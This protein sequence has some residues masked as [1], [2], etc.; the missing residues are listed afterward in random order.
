MNY[1]T[2][3]ALA[4]AYAAKV[5]EALTP[6]Q[7]AEVIEGMSDAADFIDNNQLL[8]EAW[9]LCTGE[10]LPFSATDT[11]LIQL[12]NEAQ[13]KAASALYEVEEIHP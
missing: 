9:T 7:F 3:T 2:S 13:D 11:P 5:L 10:D 6:A 1:P 8:I 12:L 4:K